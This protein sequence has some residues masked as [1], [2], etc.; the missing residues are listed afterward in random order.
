[1]KKL[2]STL[3]ALVLAT[4]ICVVG[5]APRVRTSATPDK[6][7]QKGV[8][9]EAPAK[10]QR[11][12]ANKGGKATNSTKTATVHTP[13]SDRYM[14]IKTNVAYDAVGI[15]NLDFECQVARHLSVELPVMWSFWDWKQTQGLRTVALQ[16]AL[17]WWP[18]EVGSR[19]AVGVDFDMAWFNYRHDQTR[20]QSQGRPLMGAS[21]TY[22]YTLEMGRGWQA[23]FAVAI[24]Y[25]NMQYNTYYNISDGALTGTHTR[26]YFGP[27]RLGISLVYKL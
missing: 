8:K 26:N 10:G 19:N 24:G 20:Y 17:K 21:L 25:A 14:A 13:A 6:T 3:L 16:P 22:A 5:Q 7:A 11:G 18:G 4:G 23:E 9:V 2:V 27:T 12:K 1:M 15:L